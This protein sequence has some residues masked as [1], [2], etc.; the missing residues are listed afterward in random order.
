MKNLPQE[1]EIWYLIPAL[2][3]EFAKIFVADYD[4]NQKKVAKLL[5]ISEASVSHYTNAHRG[6]NIKFSQ[7]ELKGIKV[8][9]KKIIT[10]RSPLIKELYS[11]CMRFRKSRSLC[12]I[13]RSFDKSIES[14]CRVCFKS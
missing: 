8:S 1:I 9:A 14:G 10:S 4:L 5:Q 6:Y 3:R 12:K 13:H 11:L 7:A 2:R